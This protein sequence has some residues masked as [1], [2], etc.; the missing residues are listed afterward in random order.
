MGPR[1]VNRTEE[2]VWFLIFMALGVL[3]VANL[4]SETAHWAL[5]SA[6]VAFAAAAWY[7][8]RILIVRDE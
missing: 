8:Y 6:G 1:T 5:P 4:T 3:I 7:L 2:G